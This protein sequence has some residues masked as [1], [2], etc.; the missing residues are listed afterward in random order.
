MLVEG[1]IVV[2]QKLLYVAVWCGIL[3]IYLC[4]CV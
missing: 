2:I 4:H 3:E 1:E